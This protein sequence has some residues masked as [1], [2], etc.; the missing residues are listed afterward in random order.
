MSTKFVRFVAVLA[1]LVSI[2]GNTGAVRADPAGEKAA[3]AASASYRATTWSTDWIT[4]S[5]AVSDGTHVSIAFDPGDG[6]PYVSYYDVTNGDL[7]LTSPVSSGGNCGPNNSWWCRSVV[8]IGDVGQYSS[9]DIYTAP[10]AW[11]LGIAYYDNTNHSL[12]YALYSC[13]FSC[14]WYYTTVDS[15]SDPGDTIGQYASLKFDSNGSPHIAYYAYDDADA[16]PDIFAN[17][18]LKYAHVSSGSC[19][20][21]AWQCDFV[22]NSIFQTGLYPSLDLNGANEARIAYYYAANGDLRYASA[23]ASGGNCGPG[24]NT[25][26]CDTIDGDTGSNPDVG[27]FPSLYVDKVIDNP[28]IAYYDKTNGNLK[29]AEIPS[30][31]DTYACGPL[32]SGL[33]HLWRCV[34][35]DSMGANLISHVGVSLAVDSAGYPI[36]AYQDASVD[37][38]P[39]G[40]KVAR[41]APAVGLPLGIGNCGAP[42]PGGLFN[43]W[44]CETLDYGGAHSS[45][46]DYVAIGISPSGLAMVAYSDY[47]DYYDEFNLKVAYQRL[48]VFLPLIKR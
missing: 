29:Y 31:N 17:Y 27:L 2:A 10:L 12:Q 16:W 28:K 1:I 7:M 30:G 45:V 46:A 43:W 38:A 15:S 47:E 3:T 39:A 25:W 23:G 13:F 22:E 36:I 33:F 34:P 48:Q 9:I 18:G 35:V 8:T 40:L 41:P 11:K 42:P 21:G 44:Q 24:G 6:T 4:S 37:L 32:I 19:G 5:T 14:T 26:Q 20:G